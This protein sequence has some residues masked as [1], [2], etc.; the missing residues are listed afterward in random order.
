[1]NNGVKMKNGMGT[2]GSTDIKIGMKMHSRRGLVC[3]FWIYPRLNSRWYL[4]NI[5]SYEAS[6]NSTC[7]PVGFVVEF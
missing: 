2:G 5:Y 1:M 3:H 7:N 6:P 4:E